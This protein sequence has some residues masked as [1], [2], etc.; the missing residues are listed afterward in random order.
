MSLVNMWMVL[1]SAPSCGRHLLD[2]AGVIRLFTLARSAV[3][4][5][6]AEGWHRVEEHDSLGFTH[7]WW[8][9]PDHPPGV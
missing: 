6:E 8:R 7:T 2:H 5:A 4:A 9:C 1:C 3:T